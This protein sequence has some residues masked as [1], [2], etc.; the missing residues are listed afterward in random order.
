M[1]LVRLCMVCGVWLQCD[2]LYAQLLPGLDLIPPGSRVAVANPI[3]TVKFPVPPLH[4]FPALAVIRRDVFMPILF[5]HPAQQPLAFR[6]PYAALAGRLHPIRL[7]AALVEQTKPLDA[8]EQRALSEFDYVI[9][10]ARQPF[11]LP[12]SVKLAPLFT[13][14]QL[15]VARFRSSAFSGL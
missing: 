3:D 7:F 2:R 5:A 4:H 12:V 13:S 6:Q 14:P 10:E 8:E 9:F 11:T 15:V 1:F